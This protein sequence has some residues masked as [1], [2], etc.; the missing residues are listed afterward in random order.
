MAWRHLRSGDAPRQFDVYTGRRSRG[1]RPAAARRR[2]SPS[3]RSLATPSGRRLPPVPRA[4]S[5]ALRGRGSFWRTSGIAAASAHQT[6][7]STSQYNRIAEQHRP[8]PSARRRRRTRRGRHGP[9][10]GSPRLA[11]TRTSS[12]PRILPARGARGRWRCQRRHRNTGRFAR[13]SAAGGVWL[14][15]NRLKHG[16][17]GSL[18]A[19]GVELS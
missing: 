17:R 7:A 19:A 5:S 9:R 10:P 12:S 8:R 1:F 16:I 13:G 18:Q 14:G 6:W 3:S 11:A 15:L 2:R 4:H